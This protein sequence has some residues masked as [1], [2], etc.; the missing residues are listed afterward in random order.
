MEG[1]TAAV[2]VDA[3]GAAAGEETSQPQLMDCSTPA[4][5]DPEKWVENCSEFSRPICRQVREWFFRWE[6]DLTESVKWNMICFSGRKLVAALSGCKKHVGIA[7]F[8]GNEL[9][10]PAGLFHS[11]DA[12]NASIRTVR[13]TDPKQI[14]LVLGNAGAV[15]VYVN[16]KDLGPAGADGQ[17]VHVTYTPGDP[18]AG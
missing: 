15:H 12:H 7:F 11:A 4:S 10:D 13:I 17:V 14:S 1:G 3:E 2:V 5:K 6:P 18:Q 9:P 8:R 16:G